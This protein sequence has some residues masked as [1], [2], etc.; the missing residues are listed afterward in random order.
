MALVIAYRAIDPVA[1]DGWYSA[2]Y[3]MEEDR[4]PGRNSPTLRY[5]WRGVQ[6]WD[7]FIGEHCPS[8]RFTALATGGTPRYPQRM[9][10]KWISGKRQKIILLISLLTILGVANAVLLISAARILFA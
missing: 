7:I 8:V 3:F 9:Q 4:D 10:P 2:I 6:H 5:R 1:Y